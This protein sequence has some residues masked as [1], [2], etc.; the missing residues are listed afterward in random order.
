MNIFEITYTWYEGEED[1]TYLGK[2]VNKSEFEKDLIKAKEFA[3]S[4]LGIEIKKG[5]Y[6]GKGYNTECLPEF[7][8]Q[9]IWFLINKKKYIECFLDDSDYS[10][11][12][13]EDKIIID[14][15]DNVIKRTRI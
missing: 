13:S 4:L 12:D 1:K 6:L 8:S 9:I 11:D 2:E 15:I 10:V 5:E 7:Y 14:K 3:K